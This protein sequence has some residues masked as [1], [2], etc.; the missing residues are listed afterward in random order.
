MTTKMP[1]MKRILPAMLVGIIL[2]LSGYSMTTSSH[3]MQEEEAWH[4]QKEKNGIQV[5]TR[6]EEG[7]KYKAF[8]ATA[9]IDAP[10]EWVLKLGMDVPR[11]T[12]WMADIERA[13]VLEVVNDD[14][15]VEYYES[16]VPG[17]FR[18]RDI[19]LRSKLIRQSEQKV[20]ITYRSEPEF[21]PEKDKLIRIQTADGKWELTSLSEDQTQV[22]YGMLMDP[23]GH[24]PAWIVNLFIVD[25]PMETLSNMKELSAL[26]KRF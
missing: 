24:V 9:V 16:K 2:L 12:N 1:S 15:Q 4:L 11:K 8:K 26:R 21:L 25:G 17:P 19:I 7:S 18:D 6:H 20:I 10:L 5:F 23:G 13:E 14:E 3:A 22:V